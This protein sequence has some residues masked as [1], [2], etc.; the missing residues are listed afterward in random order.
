MCSCLCV[1]EMGQDSGADQLSPENDSVYSFSCFG[2]NDWARWKGAK[3]IDQGLLARHSREGFK[4]TASIQMPSPCLLGKAIHL[5][6]GML[7]HTAST[8]KQPH[9]P[10]WLTLHES[11]LHDSL[12]DQSNKNILNLCSEMLH[13]FNSV[14]L[15]GP[16]P[17][18]HP[19]DNQGCCC[20]NSIFSKPFTREELSVTA[21]LFSGL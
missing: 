5:I 17:L 13:L 11:Y 12:R 15:P 8:S 1:T 16:C 21:C 7:S 2:F 10:N 14:M 9:P 4:D 20:C 18:L 19:S 3:Y 6:S